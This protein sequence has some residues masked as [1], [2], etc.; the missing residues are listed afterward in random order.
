[1]GESGQSLIKLLLKDA[2]TWTDLRQML[3]LQIE[4]SKKIHKEQVKYTNDEEAIDKVARFIDTLNDE[5]TNR[6]NQLDA[7]SSALIQLVGLRTSLR[8]NQTSI[9]SGLA[10]S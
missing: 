10:L 1:M 9:N 8:V 2:N 7:G 4:A 3:G 6:I 5:I